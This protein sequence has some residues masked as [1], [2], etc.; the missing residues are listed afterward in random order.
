MDLKWGCKESEGEKS[1]RDRKV[2]ARV[3]MFSVLS[4]ELVKVLCDPPLSVP[5]KFLNKKCCQTKFIVEISLY[6]HIYKM[7]RIFTR[8]L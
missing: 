3:L 6:S 7:K 2:S 4:Q 1:L 5:T 8:L